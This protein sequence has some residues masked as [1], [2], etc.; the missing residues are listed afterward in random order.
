MMHLNIKTYSRKMLKPFMLACIFCCSP[1]FISAKQLNVETKAEAAILMNADTGNILYEKNSDQLF[2][3]ASITKIATAAYAPYRVPE[4]DLDDVVIAEQDTIATISEEERRKS[5][6]TVPA[7]W[8]VPEG[9]HMGIK[10][11][12]ELPLRALLF[13]MVVASAN[14]AANMIAHHIGG[15]IPKYIDGLNAFLR[16]I[17][18]KQTTF[19]NPHGL[20][21]PKHQTTAY[22]MAM[23]MRE[24]LKYPL[25][26]EMI[27]TVRYTRPKTNKQE[28]TVLLQTNK[29]LRKGEFFYEK[30]I[31]GKTGY[32]SASG[33]TLVAA[34]K[35]GD[36][37]LIAVLLKCKKNETFKDAIALFDAAFNEKMERRLLVNQGPQAFTLELEGAAQPIKTYVKEEAA[38]EY[39]PS[40]EPKVHCVLAWATLKLPIGKDQKVGELRFQ[41]S[42]GKL[43]TIV[44][45]FAEEDVPA[46]WSWRFRHPFG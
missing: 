24:A 30:A 36:R 1:L 29:L 38:I 5:N 11:D 4:M 21:H 41:S 31:G 6:Y 16:K 17:G 13:G 28:A 15:T 37:T 8:L 46:T 42:D 26:K 23:I 25:F 32:T 35:Q 44:P 7:Y 45:L 10:R 39:L 22:D 3:P 18:C 27:G 20:Y 19:Y 34:A 12:E 40:E 2:Y 14:D 33:H 43:N 9:S